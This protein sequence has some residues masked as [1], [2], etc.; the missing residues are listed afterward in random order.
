MR[1]EAMENFTGVVVS[2]EDAA[3]RPASEVGG[4][5]HNLAVLREAGFPVPDGYVVTTTA[6]TRFVEVNGFGTTTTADEIRAA[7]LTAEMSTELRHVMDRL[8]GTV[9]VRSSGVAEDLTG[10]SYAGQYESILGVDGPQ[11]LAEAV[12]QCW[13]SAFGDH[14]RRYHAATGSGGIPAMAVL[15]QRMVP[16]E[17]AGVAFT[18]NPVT[19][20]RDELVINA[21]SGLA[22]RLVA[23]EVDGEH[24]SVRSGH[25]VRSEG[26]P[27]TLTTDQALRVARLAAEV[28]GHLE[29]PQDIE[30]AI[31]ADSV[32][33]LQAR[34]ITALP[35]PL[36]PIPVEI[37]DG[38]WERE[39]S[40]APRPWSP[41]SSSLVYEI[42]NP[43]LR[44][45]MA[46]FGLLL[47]AIEFTEIGG[48]EYMRLVP[49][50]GK[51][52]PAPPR[53]MMRVLIR[54]IPA[55]RDRI[56][57]TVAAV[58]DDLAGQLV[59]RW[60]G[61]WH[62]RMVDRLSI[63][64]S[65]DVA[66][67]SDKDLSAHWDTV[68]EHLREGARIHF[69]LH[70]ATCFSLAQLAFASED[71]LGWEE[72]RVWQL[73][74]GLSHMS[75][76]PSRQLGHLARTVAT[77]PEKRR[78]I[79][80]GGPEALDRL[81]ETDPDF[82]A[83]FGSYLDEYGMA[84]LSYDPAT[85]SLA[86]RPDLALGLLADQLVRGFDASAGD[87]R[88]AQRR[89]AVLQEA[90][91]TLEA[92][93]P[94]DRERWEEALNRA[95]RAYP[96]REDNEFFTMS[97]PIALV[98]HVA[99]GIGRRLQERGQLDAVEDVF[100]LRYGE[101]NEAIADG[102]SRLDLV[103][104][105]KGERA[106][107]EAHPGPPTYGQDPGPPPS[108]DALPAEAR[109]ANK[110]LIWYAGRIMEAERSSRDQTGV[111]IG[112]IAASPGHYRGPARIVRSEADFG[113][114]QAGD[115]LVC[116]IT[117]PVWSILFPSI[118]GL[119]TDTGGILSHP[120]IIAREYRIP[121]VVA[122]GNATSLIRDGQMVTVDGAKGVVK[123][124]DS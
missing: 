123:P 36:I 75:T 22:D 10:A 88:Q 115:V 14:L 1:E 5:A 104:R 55:L 80:E 6:F 96:I 43:P 42:R 95:A 74:A 3:H 53:W 20:D 93:S 31:A 85:R 46:D 110:A 102:D 65:T 117:S 45:V 69:T 29:S 28:A 84:A 66:A 103:R 68:L 63:L 37:P 47:D 72:S 112:G 90:M 51:D 107:V 41:L 38:Y 124:A 30:W 16:A 7:I 111:E 39:A 92:R 122:T 27:T 4:K 83:E 26:G 40:H 82:A 86:E 44:Q 121:A 100:F 33:L 21:V 49:L 94:S 71:L 52:R 98:R 116:P 13:A 8:G 32:H 106:W 24:W 58:R 79:E 91:S 23:G 64:R 12:R 34:P 2:L 109:F 70:A 18:A 62:P 77:D 50:G 73:L 81:R 60:Y 87:A 67:L 119:V 19:G 105:R 97:G 120:A 35:E 25:A 78:I 9:A 99:V 114:I 76:E 59:D 118:G 61:E 108:L 48:W 15:I 54:V 57:R 89:D 17:A 56:R 113:K 11:G 101:V